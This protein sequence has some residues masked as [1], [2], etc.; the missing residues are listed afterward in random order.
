VNFQHDYY[1]YLPLCEP[2][3]DYMPHK[4]TSVF[5]EELENKSFACQ[6]WRN[7]SALTP[8]K[9]QVPLHHGTQAMLYNNVK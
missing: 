2:Y 6:K 5:E 7:F 1:H 3:Q 4:E 8:R 9:K